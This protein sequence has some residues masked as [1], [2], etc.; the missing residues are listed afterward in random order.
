MR[1]VADHL[2]Q[3]YGISVSHQ[4]IY[5]WISR[6]A[7]MAARWMDSLGARTGE[8]WNIDETVVTS[9][10]KPRWVW[11]VED[12]STRFLLSTHVTKL[13]RIRDARVTIRRAKMATPDRP[14][15]VLTDGMPAYRL[16][17]GRELAFRS[18]AKVVN[19]HV[20]VPSIRAKRSNN[21]VERLHGTEKERIKIMRGFHSAKGSKQFMEGYR[22]HYN[23]VRPHQAL[24]TTPGTAAGLPEPG[25]FRWKGIL[26]LA[27]RK[28][29]VPAGEAE[30]VLLV[31]PAVPS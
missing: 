18:G 19:P 20:R 16:A 7:P 13:R 23:L 29:S 6:Y 10:G 17:V 11:N 30:I 2:K 4:A 3:V 15:A 24:G 22:V 31:T 14:L 5:G 1:K 9:G 8:Q 12:A 26:E 25:R 27:S 28:R 21:V